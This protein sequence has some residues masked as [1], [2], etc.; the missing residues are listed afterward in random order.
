MNASMATT[1]AP[2]RHGAAMT[3]DQYFDKVYGGWFGKCLGGAGGA[4]CEGIKQ[5]LDV[6]MRQVLDKD[7]PNDDLDIQLLWLTVLE[8]KGLAV[9]AD[10][11]AEA[12][13]A[14][15]WYPFGEYGYF[16]RNA[17]RGI[18]PPYSGGFNNAYFKEGMG[19]P[20]RSEIWA[21]VHPG[22]PDAAVAMALQDGSLDHEGNSCWGEA[23][24]AYIE[25]EA[26]FEQDIRL[27]LRRGLGVIGEPCRMRDCLT[28][29]LDSFEKGRSFEEI[30][31]AILLDYSHPDFT[32]SVQ[33][34]GFTALALLFGGGDMETTINL[35]LRCGYDA[36]CTCAS[37]GAVVG[38]LSG[39]RAI[40]EGLKDLLQDKFVCG[41]DVTRPD[42][43][44]LT[45]ARDTCAVGVGLHP[46]AV[47]RVPEDMAIPVWEKAEPVVGVTVEYLGR[48]AIGFGDACP[49][50]VRVHNGTGRTAAG[51]VRFTGLPEG[52]SAELEAPAVLRLGPGEEAAVKA[53]CRTA[54]GGFRLSQTNWLRVGLFGADGA[55]IAG[56]SFGI[57]GAMEWRVSGPFIEEYDETERRDY[58]SCHADNSTLPGIEALF[59]NMADPTKAYLDEEAYV[60]SPLSFP[61]SRLMTAYEDKL[62][63]DETFGFTGEATFYLTTDFWFPEEGE[64][65]LVIGNNDAFKLWLNGELVR[66]N[67]EVR[68]W[69]P[70]CHGDIVRLKQGRNR[71]S[72]KLTKRSKTLEFSLGIRRYEGNHYHRMPWET[73]YASIK[74]P[75]EKG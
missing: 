53:V 9:T 64:R 56:H 40:D 70:H 66:E 37:A 71:I 24:L 69:Q 38:I 72:L 46:A 50:L 19:C 51:E 52:F 41:I 63:L 20:I 14:H 42:D 27:L 18:R 58:P 7:I 10:D 30:R 25:S 68:N 48:P 67:Q 5:K 23:F 45:L 57:V 60:A 15:C 39:Y 6:T 2:V 4:R 35:A 74:M 32:N 61:C 26:F 59:S 47:E 3:Y 75:E 31:D 49:L 8:E 33:N 65:W 34:L 36:D 44:I 62:P 13:L 22:D 21:F 54:A 29:V 17:R 73:E 16:M 55:E 1:A 11:L 28:M 12:W 43:T